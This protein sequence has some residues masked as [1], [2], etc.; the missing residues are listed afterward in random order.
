MIVRVV[1]WTLAIIALAA[2][3]LDAWLDETM[4]RL[5]LIQMPAWLALGWL[6]SLL[7]GQKRLRPRSWNRHGL[8]GLI[9]AVG[10]VS[11]WMIP[12]SVDLIGASE[13][14]DQAMHASLLAAG[15][16]LGLSTPALP[17]VLRAVLGIY[18]ASMTFALGMLYGHYGALLCGTFDLIQQKTAGGY[19]LILCPIV[20]LLVL[21]RGWRALT[22]EGPT[23]A[24]RATASKPA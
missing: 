20:V 22:R 1:V 14:A 2:S 19:L 5:I 9:L 11:F 21:Y 3:P 16:L 10:A 15:L 23:Q 13:L 24:D 17:F 18:G 8:T 4:S 7:A 12:R 6:A